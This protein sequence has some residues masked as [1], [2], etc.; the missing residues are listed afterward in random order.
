MAFC[1]CSPFI[2]HYHKWAFFRCKEMGIF[3]LLLH[4]CIYIHHTRPHPITKR[5]SAVSPFNDVWVRHLQ[6]V[7]YTSQGSHSLQTRT[8]GVEHTGVAVSVLRNNIAIISKPAR[9]RSTPEISRNQSRTSPN[10]MDKINAIV[11]SLFDAKRYY[12]I[13]LHC[14]RPMGKIANCNLRRCNRLRKQQSTG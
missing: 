9:Y 10:R 13:H 2:G 8:L 11:K 3:L 6:Q 7:P 5:I 14:F 4:F 12:A 1:S